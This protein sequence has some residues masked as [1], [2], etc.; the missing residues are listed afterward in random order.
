MNCACRKTYKAIS[1]ASE[2]SKTCLITCPLRHNDEL[3]NVVPNET[4][5]ERPNKL[6]NNQIYSNRFVLRP[7]EY[8]SNWKSFYFV[9]SR[10]VSIKT[11]FKKV[12]NI[13]Q[14]NV[15]G[16]HVYLLQKIVEPCDANVSFGNFS[17]ICIPTHFCHK[18]LI[19]FLILG[20]ESVETRR[21]IQ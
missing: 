17:Y 1:R 10:R 5:E 8:I 14:K 6:N 16:I 11:C 7:F 3:D 12:Y 13:T 21:L 20:N 18:K 15:N 19:I 4:V 9:T 2:S